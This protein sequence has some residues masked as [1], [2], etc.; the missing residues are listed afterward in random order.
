MP[1]QKKKKKYACNKFVECNIFKARQIRHYFE[2]FKVELLLHTYKLI[3]LEY[4]SK[5]MQFS[6]FLT[7]LE[8]SFGEKVT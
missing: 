1:H 7:E 3:K 6:K 5:F 4:V 2:L 8:V